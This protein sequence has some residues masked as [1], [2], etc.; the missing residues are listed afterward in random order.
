LHSLFRPSLADPQSQNPHR[1]P[2][3]PAVSFNRID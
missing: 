3:A 1:S 2:A